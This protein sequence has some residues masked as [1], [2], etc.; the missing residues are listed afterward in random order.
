MG[1][2]LPL[3]KSLFCLSAKAVGILYIGALS[4][5]GIITKHHKRNFLSLGSGGQTSK[6]T[7]LAGLVPPEAVKGSL[8]QAAALT[9]GGSWLCRCISPSL[10]PSSSG[11]RPG[12]ASIPR[13]PCLCGYQSGWGRGPLLQCDPILTNYNF[14]D[15]P[16]KVTF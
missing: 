15:L 16:G 10:P 6:I 1:G 11:A 5:Q 9:S 3:S 13:F 8:V 4:A 7:L 12:C 2:F 14:S